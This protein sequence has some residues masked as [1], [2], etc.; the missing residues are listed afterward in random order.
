MSHPVIPTRT[1]ADLYMDWQRAKAA[2]E[3]T[4]PAGAD[5]LAA[6]RAMELASACL[7]RVLRRRWPVAVQVGANVAA[8]LGPLDGRIDWF[9]LEPAGMVP[10]RPDEEPSNYPDPALDPAIAPAPAAQEVA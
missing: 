6:C 3:A 10:L 8:R 4:D 1:V 5:R 7:K 2:L 9:V